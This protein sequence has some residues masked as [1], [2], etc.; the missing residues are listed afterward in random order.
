MIVRKEIESTTTFFFP[1]P[2]GRGATI[3]KINLFFASQ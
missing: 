1:P 2:G 3:N